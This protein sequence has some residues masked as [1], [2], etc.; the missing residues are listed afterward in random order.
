MIDCTSCVV[1]VVT[2]GDEVCVT[3]SAK[4]GAAVWATVDVVDAVALVCRAA[5]S[6]VLLRWM[7]AVD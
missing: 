3:D 6:G 4:V 5:T 1:A 7:T 2:A